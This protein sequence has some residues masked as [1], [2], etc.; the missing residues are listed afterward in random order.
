MGQSTISLQVVFAATI[1]LITVELLSAALF[2]G[3]AG[4]RLVTI[5]IVRMFEIVFMVFLLSQWGKGLASVGL[6]RDKIAR[7]FGRGL[8]WSAAFG[9]CIILAAGILRFAGYRIFSLPV[10]TVQKNGAS[11]FLLFLVGGLISPLAEE[12]FFRGIIYGYLRRWSVVLA[13]IGS[14]VIFALA[15]FLTSG[16]SYVQIIGGLVFAVAYEIEKNLLVPIAIHVLGNMAIF[17]LSFLVA[18]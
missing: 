3:A 13:V 14:T 12:I 8:V 18:S 11:I 7:G 10:F 1:S 17:A 6:L 9:I 2:P 5:G 16:L 15:H 4:H